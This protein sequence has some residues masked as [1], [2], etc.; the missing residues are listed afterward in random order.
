MTQMSYVDNYVDFGD[1]FLKKVEE[2]KNRKRN[3][4]FLF[5]KLFLPNIAKY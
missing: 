3:M 5:C 4:E 2:K 1:F